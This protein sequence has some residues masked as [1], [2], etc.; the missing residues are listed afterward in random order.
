MSVVKTKK[1]KPFHP[2]KMWF[3]Q[4][5]ARHNNY[6]ISTIKQIVIMGVLLI[7]PSPPATVEQFSVF[8]L[9]FDLAIIEWIVPRIAY[10]PETYHVIYQEVLN[11]VPQNPA[12]ISE[13][14]N[15]TTN[16][17][18]VDDGYVVV[19]RNLEPDTDY[20]YSIT[21]INPVTRTNSSQGVFITRSNDEGRVIF[22]VRPCIELGLMLMLIL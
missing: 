16:I 11:G 9:S 15:G 3:W 18:S 1:Y 20:M 4:S 8:G 22:P 10:V 7:G 5:I 14:V 12:Y 19:L 21:S 17:T 6:K 2:S 13:R